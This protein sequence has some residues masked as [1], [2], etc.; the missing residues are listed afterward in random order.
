MDYPLGTRPHRAG[1]EVAA[2]THVVSPIKPKAAFGRCRPSAD[3]V[4]N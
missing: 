2:D 4:Q 1:C 3:I